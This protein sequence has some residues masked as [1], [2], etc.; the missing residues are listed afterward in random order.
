MALTLTERTLSL[1]REACKRPTSYFGPDVRAVEQRLDLTGK[2]VLVVGG[3][4][5][6]GAATLLELLA[7]HPASVVVMDTSENNLAELVRT[8]RSGKRPFDGELKVAPLDYGSTLADRYMGSL[9]PMDVVLSFAALKHVR[10]ERDAYSCLA[11]LD[12]NVVRADRFLFALRRHGHGSD[13]VFFVSTDKAAA[14]ASVMGASKRLMELVLW[15]HAS[16]SWQQRGRSGSLAPLPRV[17]TVRFANVAYSDGS[18][19]WAFLQ[20]IE[21][22]QP[23]GAPRD[24]RRYLVTAEEAGHLC[25]LAARACPHH[26]LLVPR[27]DPVEHTV[28]FPEMAEVTLR[29]FGFEP[30]WYDMEEQ[31]RENLETDVRAGRYPVVL[32]RAD[33]S[34][35]KSTEVFWGPS[36][37]VES[38]GLETVDAVR[39][40]AAPE[41]ALAELLAWLD[42]ALT[43]ADADLTKG[44][45]VQALSALVPDIAHKET[46]QSLDGRI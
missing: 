15:A 37:S 27:L 2:N 29:S 5:T 17:T 42:R 43:S 32:T 16:E 45:V 35:E 34:G 1:A 9:P 26:H 38:V 21:K 40:V 44:G 18:L 8:V 11:L 12:V 22:K 10:S 20:R 39:G 23:L 28:V 25:L 13:G 4:G 14:P 24:V 19:P 46:G 33:T 31:A 6:I 36:E 3:A 7:F 30:A 41:P